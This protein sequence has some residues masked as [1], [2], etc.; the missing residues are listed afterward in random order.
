MQMESGNR[1]ELGETHSGEQR[2]GTEGKLTY[3][4]CIGK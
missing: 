1:G 3:V 4:S 2:L